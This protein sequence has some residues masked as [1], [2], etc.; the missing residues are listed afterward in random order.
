[1]SA[2]AFETPSAAVCGAELTFETLTDASGAW[3]RV[4]PDEVLLKV[5][6]GRVRI[7][8]DGY[9]WEM[10]VEGETR[11]PAGVTHRLACAGGGI[12]RVAQQF[13]ACG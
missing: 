3:V 4:R 6:C 5:V 8:V 1:M 9:S 11:I 2:T 12:A 7:E 10:P 13:R